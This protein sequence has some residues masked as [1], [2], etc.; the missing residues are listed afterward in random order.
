MSAVLRKG[1]E[2]WLQRRCK[3]FRKRNWRSTIVLDD[4]KK[5][6]GKALVY[7]EKHN[8]TGEAVLTSWHPSTRRLHACAKKTGWSWKIFMWS[9]TG[10]NGRLFVSSSKALRIVRYLVWMKNPR[11]A[12]CEGRENRSNKRCINL[13]N[14]TAHYESKMSSLQ[15]VWKPYVPRT[16]QV[17]HSTKKRPVPMPCQFCYR[18]DMYGKTNLKML[19]YSQ[20]CLV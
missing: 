16:V 1:K 4:G 13:R 19:M 10:R 14:V 20:S 18:C 5:E 12:S 17:M 3:I 11:S 9:V 8:S 2:P 15:L 7:Q 6:R